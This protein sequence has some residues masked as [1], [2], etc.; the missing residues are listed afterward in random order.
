MTEIDKATRE[1][2]VIAI[3]RDFPIVRDGLSYT[4]KVDLARAVLAAFASAPPA[5]AP[6]RDGWRPI[7]SAP[8]AEDVLLWCPEKGITNHARIELGQARNGRGSHHAW[9]TMWSP[10]PAPPRET[11][12]AGDAT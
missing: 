12:P 7:D 4:E 2:C 1:R 11:P 5:P 3:N 10:L 9:A 6:E 8:D